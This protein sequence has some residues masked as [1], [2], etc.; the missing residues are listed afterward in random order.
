MQ[1]LTFA[2]VALVLFFALNQPADAQPPSAR[3]WRVGYLALV[4]DGLPPFRQALSE[5]GYVEGRNLELVVR[6]ADGPERLPALAADLVRERVDVV[7]ASSPPAILAAKDATTAVPI[8]MGAS[9]V[10][11]VKAGFVA[12]LNRPGGNVTGVAILADVLA[13]KRLELAKQLVPDAKRIALLAIDNELASG[14]QLAAAQAAAQKLGLETVTL[15]IRSANDYEGAF[16]DATQ[17]AQAMVMLVHPMF[18]KDRKLIV[19]L[20]ARHRVRL[21]CDW[22]EMAQA[23]CLAAYG[24]SLLGILRSAAR[25]VDRVLRGAAPGE[26]AVELPDT[27]NIVINRDTAAAIGVAVPGE[28]LLRAR[29]VP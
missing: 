19:D 24:P 11:P 5:L 16:A 29:V 7:L 25:H 13:G 23:G 18:L 4:P 14:P 12:S 15:R 10:D 21:V 27:F 6:L 9:G 20:A 28:L 26:L 1:T 17:R 2:L 8:V 22:E 3:M